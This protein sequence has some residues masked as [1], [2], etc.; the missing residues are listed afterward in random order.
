VFTKSE[1]Q[2]NTSSILFHQCIKPQ[3]TQCEIFSVGNSSKNKRQHTL[4]RKCS[5]EVATVTRVGSSPISSF[6]SLNAV[7]A[8]SASP[9]SV[10]PPGNV[11][12]PK[13]SRRSLQIHKQMRTS[14]QTDLTK[15][16]KLFK[17][18]GGNMQ[19]RSINE[20]NEQAKYA[21]RSGCMRAWSV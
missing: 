21:Y 3:C 6:D 17:E 13:N 9:S 1:Q 18:K 15:L 14:G 7:A 19:D 12:S 16:T 5:R 11:T 20:E 4:D 10:F 2:T 8:S